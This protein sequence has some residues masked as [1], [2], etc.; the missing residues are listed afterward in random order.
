MTVSQG[1][2]D[3]GPDAARPPPG[4]NPGQLLLTPTHSPL[5]SLVQ[6]PAESSPADPV[7]VGLARTAS[8]SPDDPLTRHSLI[9]LPVPTHWVRTHSGRSTEAG[10]W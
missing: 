6:F 7:I 1:F 5:S 8:P 4:T 9:Q 3:L 2:F 10:R